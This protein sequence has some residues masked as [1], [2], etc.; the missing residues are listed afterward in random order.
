VN[1][2]D[3]VQQP[4]DIAGGVLGPDFDRVL[5]IPSPATPP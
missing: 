5:P 1:G 3:A 2:Y 4:T